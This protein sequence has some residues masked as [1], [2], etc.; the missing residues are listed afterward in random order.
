[1]PHNVAS[2]RAVYKLNDRQRTSLGVSY[3]SCVKNPG[4]RDLSTQQ[5]YWKKHTMTSKEEHI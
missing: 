5:P 3:V 1:M 4:K 2:G